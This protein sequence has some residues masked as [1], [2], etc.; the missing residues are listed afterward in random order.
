[1]SDPRHMHM[2][3][4]V[5]HAA[6]GLAVDYGPGE[7][8]EP[9]SLPPGVP[10]RDVLVSDVQAAVAPAWARPAAEPQPD[11]EPKAETKTE[12]KTTAKAPA[13]KGA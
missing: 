10:Y 3:T 7:L 5:M 11:P 9:G 12:A 4:D 1:M 8:H 6:D 13:A 2:V